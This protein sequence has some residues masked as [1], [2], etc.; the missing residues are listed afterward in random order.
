MKNLLLTL[1]LVAFLPHFSFTQIHCGLVELVPN[2]SVNELLTFDDFSKYEG[3]MIINSVAKVRVKVE[4]QA[5]P[6]P[7]CS[8]SLTMQV[9]NNPGAG[10]PVDEWEELTQYGNGLNSNPTIDFL[11][12]RV[13]N[14]CQTSPIDGTFVTFTNNGD[15]IDIIAPIIPVTPPDVVAAGSCASGVNGSGS[16]LTDYSEFNFD[17]DI[18]VKPDFTLNPGIFQLNITFHLEENP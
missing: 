8:W 7:L 6:D 17:I 11:E 1:A 5:V 10:T 3:G 4:D 14:A 12:V 15:L 2:T 16:Y 18:R 13:R 9:D